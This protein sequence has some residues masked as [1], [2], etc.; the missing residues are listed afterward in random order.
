MN[1]AFLI[2]PLV[3]ITAVSVS[4]WIQQARR[5][6]YLEK[7]VGKLDH[8]VEYQQDLADVYRKLYFGGRGW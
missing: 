7:R 5:A 4:A 6:A 3:L 1:P 2:V 8:Q